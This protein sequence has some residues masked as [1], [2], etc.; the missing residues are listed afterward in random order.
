MVEIYVVQKPGFYVSFLAHIPLFPSED[1]KFGLCM[2][3]LTAGY[4]ASSTWKPWTG[5]ES[6]S[7]MNKL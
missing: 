2:N 5:L 4:V 6:D 1:P 7:K 3:F